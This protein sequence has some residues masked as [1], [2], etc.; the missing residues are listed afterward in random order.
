MPHIILFISWLFSL[1]KINK[2]IPFVSFTFIILLL[3]LAFRYNYGNDYMAY[4]SIHQALNA[5]QPAWG[6]SDILF[7]LINIIIPNFYIYI[8]VIS[9]FYMFII[10]YLIQ[11]NLKLSDY[12][13][14]LLI[15]LL[16][17]Y[18]F[19]IHLSSI[20]QTIAICVIVISVKFI[21]EKKL[22]YFLFTVLIAAG[23]HAS[24]IIIL[25]FYFL[26]NQS[27]IK[28]RWIIIY[29]VTIIILL[30]SPIFELIASNIMA[31]FPQYQHYLTSDST[32]SLR[33]SIVTS[34]ILFI[35]LLNIN[36]M[37]G[38]EIIF[39]KLALVALA[40][41]ILSYKL[42]MLARIGMYFDIYL[43]IA[44]PVICRKIENTVLRYLVYAAII[45]I[46]FFRYISFFS[47]PMWQEY[48]ST[49]HTVF[50]NF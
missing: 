25:P 16:N 36:K 17:P 38:K 35:V 19:L 48:Y 7:K 8:F 9:L 10:Y 30:V 45:S 43:I 46:Y 1:P 39:G 2:K 20:R 47:N 11:N 24:A 18:L 41:S 29:L 26:L 21:I 27:K 50:S 37:E 31:Y 33:S 14:S 32:S 22:L 5:G 23:F 12:W 3:F 44:L 13:F 34:I 4:F 15:L 49:Y 28:M 40:L 6:G 42:T